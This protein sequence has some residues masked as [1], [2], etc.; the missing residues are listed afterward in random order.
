[1]CPKVKYLLSPI[2]TN[3]FDY[4]KIKTLYIKETVTVFLLQSPNQ[5]KSNIIC[6]RGYS[7]PRYHYYRRC[8]PC[9]VYLPLENVPLPGITFREC[10]L[11]GYRIL[12]TLRVILPCGIMSMEQFVSLVASGML[13]VLLIQLLYER[14]VL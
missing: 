13:E 14:I 5:A 3:F 1:M 6:F 4:S 10:P 11:A 9:R 2:Y 8:Y 7:L 12:F